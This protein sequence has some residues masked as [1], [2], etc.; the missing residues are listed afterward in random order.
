M[1]RRPCAIGIHS[2]FP[3]VHCAGV[4]PSSSAGMCCTDR[5]T[6]IPHRGTPVGAALHGLV[7]CIGPDHAMDA[8]PGPGQPCVH[9]TCRS[10]EDN[11]RAAGR[12]HRAP[13]R[14]LQPGT[15]GVQPIAGYGAALSALPAEV[16]DA[17]R[18]R[19][20]SEAYVYARE[21]ARLGVPRDRIEQEDASAN[22]WE[23]ARN[24]SAMLRHDPSRV[25]IVTSGLREACFI[26]R[27]SA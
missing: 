26:S 17:S 1:Q 18:N 4:H 14:G 10:A 5:H 19:K 20:T 22:T 16:R 13:S 25:V 24:S 12:W 15:G 21:L 11:D 27:I 2:V 9:D 23:N 3:E 7:Q 6:P 8:R